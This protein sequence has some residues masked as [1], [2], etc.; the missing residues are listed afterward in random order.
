MYRVNRPIHVASWVI[1]LSN[2]LP[3]FVRFEYIYEY[4][5]HLLI[6]MAHGFQSPAISLQNNYTLF[7]DCT[8]EES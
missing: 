6:L 4:R 2:G 3:F 5:D 7:K 1:M 8:K